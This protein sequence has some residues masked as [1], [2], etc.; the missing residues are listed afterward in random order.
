MAL[1][2][3]FQTEITSIIWD[4][5]ILRWHVKTNRSDHFIAQ[6]VVLATGIQDKPK[7]HGIPG[8][9]N[10]KRDHFYSV[11]WDYSITG[12]DSTGKLEKLADKTVGI[13][14]TGASGVQLVPLL[15]KS[16]KK[17]YVFQRT[18]SSIAIRNN[19]KLDSAVI[20]SLKPGR[21]EQKLNDFAYIM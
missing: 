19:W 2:A 11:R 13:I 17:L 12:G 9:K 21:Q 5:S 4:E 16:V 15:S 10:F 1:N 20:K 14:G 7:L 3:R 8:I 6:Y 18:L